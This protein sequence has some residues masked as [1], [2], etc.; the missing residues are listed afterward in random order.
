MT[1]YAARITS[2]ELGFFALVVRIDK[3]GSEQ[4]DPCFRARHFA[5]RKSAE[6]SIQRYLSAA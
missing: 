1:T 2:T 6:R 5:T 4:I 3:D